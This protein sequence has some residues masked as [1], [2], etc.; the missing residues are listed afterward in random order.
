[1]HTTVLPSYTSGGMGIGEVEARSR[2]SVLS[3]ATKILLQFFLFACGSP[4]KDAKLFCNTRFYIRA[5]CHTWDDIVCNCPALWNSFVISQW[6]SDV[7]LDQYITRSKDLSLNIAFVMA[8][9]LLGFAHPIPPTRRTLSPSKLVASLLPHLPR[10]KTFFLSASDPRAITAF[11]NLQPLA[12]F[13]DLEALAVARFSWSPSVM[14][15]SPLP[16]GVLFNSL[17]DSV[18]FLRISFLPLP[19]SGTARCSHITTLVFTDFYRSEYP[20]LSAVVDILMDAVNLERLSMRQFGCVLDNIDV[21]RSFV[22]HCVSVLDLGFFGDESSAHMLALFK[23]PRLRDV[24]VYYCHPDDNACL[25]ICAHVFSAVTTFSMDGFCSDG[26]GMV[27]IILGLTAVRFIDMR[28]DGDW[29]VEALLEASDLLTVWSGTPTVIV[30]NLQ[31]LCIGAGVFS[32][33]FRRLFDQ[34][35][36][37]TYN[38]STI[39]LWSDYTRHLGGWDENFSRIHDNA[40]TSAYSLQRSYA[41]KLSLE[42]TL[43]LMIGACNPRYHSYSDQAVDCSREGGL[44][45]EFTLSST[46]VLDI[47]T[48]SR[49]LARVMELLSS[50]PKTY[51]SISLDLRQPQLLPLFAVFLRSDLANVTRL[52]VRGVGCRDVPSNPP[53]L[54]RMAYLEHLDIATGQAWSFVSV[55]TQLDLPVVRYLC[56]RIEAPDSLE[57]LARCQWLSQVR[58]LDLRAVCLSLGTIEFPYPASVVCTSVEAASVLLTERAGFRVEACPVLTIFSFS[59]CYPSVLRTF[60]GMRSAAGIHTYAVTFR[61]GRQRRPDELQDLKW[62]RTRVTPIENEPRLMPFWLGSWYD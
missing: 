30:P 29:I 11:Q 17:P 57:N 9:S 41:S 7:L 33:R 32:N 13:R 40:N 3:C 37:V 52:S 62:L 8:D 58:I 21:S 60:V 25:S 10:C 54:P 6:Y 23:L 42:L 50:N 34:R 24:H 12:H 35:R 19:M 36:L 59:E 43:H 20:R 28:S 53:V 48:P 27:D 26:E 4:F 38:L 39:I 49:H 56:F 22:H 44:T 47:L 31:V 55:M 2:A 46:P 61:S 15:E 14:E 16:Q 1:M 51:K 18:R 45:L 5:V